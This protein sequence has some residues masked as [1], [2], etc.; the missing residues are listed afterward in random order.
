MSQVFGA[1]AAHVGEWSIDAADHIGEGR[2]PTPSG[3]ASSLRR[4]HVG[5]RRCVLVWVAA[6]CPPRTWLGLLGGGEP[7]G[8]RWIVCVVSCTG[9]GGFS[10]SCC[11]F[12]DCSQGVVDSRR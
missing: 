11:E 12:D 5:R 1:A 10:L 2:S 4:L 6:G 7:F 9:R 8:G 3:P